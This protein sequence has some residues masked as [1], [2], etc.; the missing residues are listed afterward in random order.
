MQELFVKNHNSVHKL[1]IFVFSYDHIQPHHSPKFRF[2]VL[3]QATNVILSIISSMNWN[4]KIILRKK[5]VHP[6]VDLF[7]SLSKNS[8]FD[9][10]TEV[11]GATKTK[12]SDL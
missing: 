2:R 11:K 5:Q 9:R 7:F 8:F 4:L 1:R 10:L 3:F 6:K 12:N